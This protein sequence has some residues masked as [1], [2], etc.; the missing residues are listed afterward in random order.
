MEW[1]FIGACGNLTT[2]VL[3]IRCDHRNDRSRAI[4]GSVG[5]LL[6]IT[7][8]VGLNVEYERI[9]TSLGGLDLNT[10]SLGL[11]VSF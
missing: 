6:S 8:G 2:E 5:A 11:R 9:D 10:V 4:V 1:D 7:E 3:Q